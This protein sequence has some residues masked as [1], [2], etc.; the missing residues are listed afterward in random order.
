MR[1]VRRRHE[2]EELVEVVSRR[3]SAMLIL[4]LEEPGASRWWAIVS[5]C[6]SS[7][8]CFSEY[9][10]ASLVRS[11]VRSDPTIGSKALKEQFEKLVFQL[12][13]QLRGNP[14]TPYILAIVV[15]ALDECSGDDDIRLLIHL[16][17]RSKSL[18]SV[19]LRVF[20]T[21]RPEL[22]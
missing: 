17:S 9:G 14:E 21:S 22:W 10:G 20:V 6:L 2:R 13:E 11:A 5:Y 1:Y 15:D 12:L 19:R 4:T 8:L 3:V 18:E 16:L 7:L